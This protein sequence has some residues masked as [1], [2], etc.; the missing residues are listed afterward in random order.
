MEAARAQQ[1]QQQALHEAAIERVAELREQLREAE[2][3]AASAEA[4]LSQSKT[5]ELLLRA[6][7]PAAVY[8]SLKEVMDSFYKSWGVCDYYIKQDGAAWK[9]LLYQQAHGPEWF[10]GVLPGFEWD[11]W[12]QALQAKQAGHERFSDIP[13]LRAHLLQGQTKEAEAEAKAK[14]LAESIRRHSEL[15]QR[16]KRIGASGGSYELEELVCES[17]GLCVSLTDQLAEAA[18][19]LKIPLPL[20]ML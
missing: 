9:W 5:A 7:A 20:G 17:E 16:I 11:A 19:F 10:M 4:A 1:H 6:G 2:R 15:S 14:Q 13:A 12:W 3:D 18:G 8:D